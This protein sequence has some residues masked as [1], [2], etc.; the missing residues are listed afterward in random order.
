MRG[1]RTGTTIAIATLL[2]TLASVTT[3]APPA[4]A[5]EEPSPADI[6]AAR[7]LGQEGV[8]LADA[9]NCAE[10]IDRL[11]RAEKIFHAP[12]TLGRLG[13]CQ[14]QI[15]KLIEGTENLNRV[16]REPLASTAPPAFVAAQE[17]AGRV[18][19]EAKPKIAK[20]RIAVN[21][22]PNV[23]VT[24]T[25]DGE[26][27]P[28]ANLEANRPM[29]PGEH[30]V[31]ATSP[32]YTKASAKVHLAE[33]AAESVTLSLEAAPPPVGVAPVP[34]PVT[35]DTPSDGGGHRRRVPAFVALGVGA[36]GV[37][38]GAVF[39][40]MALGK[41]SDLDGACTAGKI[42]PSSQQDTIDSGQTFGTVSTIG[43]GVGIVGIGVGTYL[44]LTNRSKP[45][46]TPAAGVRPLL[47]AGFVGAAGTF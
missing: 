12:T 19:A 43:F 10:A 30:V 4:R 16:V 22:P 18:L 36:A 6:A 23:P 39:G 5:D 27:V 24:V 44:L 1:R 2:A 9:G 7:S 29:D 33:G 42:C 3:F 20:L 28:R 47:G 15:G 26:H 25:V 37:G 38:I 41:K 11:T 17:R 40:I 32:G 46:P 34:V 21:G 45:A 14:V 35:P 8:K 31:E 13:E